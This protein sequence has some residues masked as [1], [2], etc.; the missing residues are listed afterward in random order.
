MASQ[1]PPG[2]RFDPLLIEMWP[3]YFSP[4]DC[5]GPAFEHAWLDGGWVVHRLT[6]EARIEKVMPGP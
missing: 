6:N 2:V 3:S 1:L 4:R 5:M